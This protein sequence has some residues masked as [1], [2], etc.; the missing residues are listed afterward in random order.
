MLLHGHYR[1]N[2]LMCVLQILAGFPEVT[3]RARAAA[4]DGL[5]DRQGL[6]SGN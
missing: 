6:P 4:P 3:V 1:H 5:S 2:A